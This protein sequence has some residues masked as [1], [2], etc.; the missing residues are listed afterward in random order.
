M[1]RGLGGL[2]TQTLVPLFGHSE[3]DTVALGKGDV[4][5]RRLSDHEDVGQTGGKSVTSV[6]L[7][8]KKLT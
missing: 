4:G 3:L 2:V 5:L 6:V 1:T 7:L 8:I